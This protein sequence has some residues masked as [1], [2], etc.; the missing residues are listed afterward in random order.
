[1]SYL[2][3]FL[4]QRSTFIIPLLKVFG[5]REPIMR[6]WREKL[7]V[8]LRELAFCLLSFQLE[9]KLSPSPELDFI[10]LTKPPNLISHWKFPSKITSGGLSATQNSSNMFQLRPLCIRGKPQLGSGSFSVSCYL[11]RI[12]ELSQKQFILRETCLRNVLGT[13]AKLCWYA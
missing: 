11:L 2:V 8:M 4:W 13:N 5:R 7:T 3:L 1:M 9:V 10:T 6:T 12:T